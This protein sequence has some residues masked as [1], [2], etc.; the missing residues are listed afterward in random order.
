MLHIHP[1]PAFDDNY[2]WLLHNTRDAV[3]VD[4]GDPLPVLKVLNKLQLKLK[5][6]LITH[7]HADHICGVIPL[8]ERFSP[9]VYAPIYENYT[10]EHVELKDGDTV[11][12]SE[13]SQT[14]KVMWLPG[15]TLGHIVYVNEESLFC[16]D[17]LFGA[18]CGRLFEGTPQQMLSSLNRLKELNINTKV[19]CTHEYTNKN[20]DFALTLDSE[21]QDLIKR[22]NEVTMLLANKLPSLPST[23]E[24]E[25]K[26]N[27][28]LRCNQHSIQINS[29]AN[30][31]DE[32]S[33]FTAIRSLRNHY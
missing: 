9:K 28:F 23:I 5:S 4:P 7:H 22:K 21:N 15:H 29:H 30:S 19:Y 32:L 14:F 31:M 6:I 26:T 3:V 13:I 10:F 1:I 25:L 11:E 2:I 33:V 27:P 8:I 16:G 24:Q 12:L 20:I 17:T 18:G